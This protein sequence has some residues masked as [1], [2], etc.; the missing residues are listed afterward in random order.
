[1]SITAKIIEDIR[2]KVVLYER[3]SGFAEAKANVIS[4]LKE[5]KQNKSIKFQLKEAE[6][7][8]EQFEREAENSY[9]EAHRLFE[10]YKD[11]FD[12]EELKEANELMERLNL[13]VGFI[14]HDRDQ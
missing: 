6:T 10:N 9:R 13:G 5:H 2:E 14:D 11:D 4:G 12:S 8:K 3:N 1:M 7:Y